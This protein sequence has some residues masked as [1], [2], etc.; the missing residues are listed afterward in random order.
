VHITIVDVGANSGYLKFLKQKI[1]I[2][3]KRTCYLLV[4]N[5]HT[6]TCLDTCRIHQNF[7]KIENNSSKFDNNTKSQCDKSYC[8]NAFCSGFSLRLYAVGQPLRLT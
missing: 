6:G 8:S 1:S 2:Q 3:E 4:I 5:L 7:T